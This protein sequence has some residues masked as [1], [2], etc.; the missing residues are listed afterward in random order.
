MT[1]RGRPAERSVAVTV[2]GRLDAVVRTA[3]PGLSRRLVRSLIAE[4]LVRIDGHRAAKGARVPAGAVVTVPALEPRPA[5]E[6]A[7]DVPI[8]HEDEHLV[9]LDKPGGMPAHALDPR[10]RGTVAAFVL[11][12]Y[13]ETAGVGDPLAP[14]LVHRLD[15]GTSGL[16][17]V[18]RTPE[19]YRHLREALRTHAVEK[20][21][22]ALVAGRPP[23]AH[24]RVEVPLAHDPHDR[25]RMVA[26]SPGQRT[27]PAST[28]LR[29]AGNAGP[30]ALVEAIMHT[31]VTHQVRVHLALGGHPVVGDELYGGPP[32]GLPRGRHAL[33]AVA[34]RFPHPVTGEPVVIT[35]EL[36]AE[37]ARL[38][39][40]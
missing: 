21:Y 2:G 36:P 18:A 25:R 40:R 14:G 23:A 35:S 11:A 4:G 30:H 7:L 6:P 8:V 12:R 34:L 20:R 3:L 26:A 24:W 13:P 5:P 38:A 31:G 33:H 17:L 15:T 32:A 16:L 22:L 19:A 10:E 28:E 37:L 39:T 1:D 27:W 9:V 29:V